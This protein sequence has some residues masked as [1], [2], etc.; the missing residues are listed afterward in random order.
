LA[1]VR[2]VTRQ[3]S[4]EQRKQQIREAATRCF[5]RRGYAETRLLDIAR[6]AGLSKGGVYFHYKKKDEL[7]HDI[8]ENLSTALR[9]RWSASPT[10]DKPA[11]RSLARL[12]EAHLRTIQ[13]HPDEV[14]LQNLL[15]AMAV[16]EPVFQDKLE[17]VTR[18]MHELYANLI[19]RGIHEGVFIPG[20]TSALAFA[21]LAFVHGLA[22]FT[23]LDDEG[24]L[25]ITPELAADQVLR[26]LRVHTRASAVEFGPAKQWS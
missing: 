2:T 16:Q 26:M 8:L 25:P 19:Q 23:V 1:S 4:D 3:R 12:V 14:R 20:D 21:V 15:V 10:A 18:I 9:E 17:Q 6:E 22:A 13:D 7:F 5:V 11:D 24:R